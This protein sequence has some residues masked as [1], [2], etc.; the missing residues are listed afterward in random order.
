MDL[1]GFLK[2][3]G[4]INIDPEDAVVMH[5]R[6]ATSGGVSPQK[7][8]PFP[9]TDDLELMEALEYTYPKVLFHNGILGAGRG[10]MSD[11]QV[12][13]LEL[14][15]R[16]KL[17]SDVIAKEVAWNKIV[18][19]EPDAA[20]YY[21]KWYEEDGLKFSNDHW[22]PYT[23]RDTDWVRNWSKS[24][25]LS[26]MPADDDIEGAETYVDLG[27]KCPTCG[28]KKLYSIAD[29]ADR[30]GICD[31][32]GQEFIP[33]DECGKWTAWLDANVT[34]YCMRCIAKNIS[35]AFV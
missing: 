20:W 25:L 31:A 15:F 33:C 9:I 8:H 11:T 19:I 17:D 22:K 1:D 29:D 26:E 6:I 13:A 4:E 21:G 16:D 14:S 7:C 12:Y 2:A 30:I 35:N 32:C 28:K 27:V 23:P 10:H 18:T 24:A 3:I 34:P 5:F